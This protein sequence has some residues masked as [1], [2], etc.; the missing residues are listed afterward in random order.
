MRC[1]GLNVLFDSLARSTFTDFEMVLVDGLYQHRADIVRREAWSRFLRVAHVE[2]SPNP[3]PS[4][5]FCQYSNTG[6]IHASG[7]VVLFLVDYTRVPPDLL[8]KHAEF[9]RADTTGRKGMMGPHRYVRLDVHRDWPRY[10]PGD[11]DKYEADVQAGDLDE[12]IFSIGD[13][14]DQPSAP[15]RVDGG[16][17]AQPDADPKLRMNAGPITADFFHAKNESVRLERCLEINGWD[18]ALDGA[19]VHQD[20]DFADRLSLRA[21]VTWTL[22]P[23]AVVDIANPRG[24]FPFARRTRSW[25]SNRER[26]QK[27]KAAGYPTPNSYSLR[28]RRTTPMATALPTVAVSPLR[29][30]MVYGEFSTAIHGPF[31]PPNLHNAALTGSESSFFNLARTMA[32]RGHQVVAFCVCPEPYEHP[33]GLVI[34]PIQALRGLP[35]M[36]LEAVIAWNEPDYLQFAPTDV[37]RVVDQQ[38]NDFGY[39]RHP[40]WRALVDLWVSPSRHHLDHLIATEGVPGEHSFVVPNSVDLDLFCGPEPERHPHRAVWCSSPDRGLHHLLSMWPD[41]RAVVPDAELR[42]FYRLGPWL[43]RVRDMDDEVGRRARYIEYA[44][45]RLRVHG[46][47]VV[48]PVANAQMATE[49]R[50]AKLLAY[51]CDPVRYTEGFGCSVLDAAAAGCVPLISDADALPSVHRSGCIAIQGKPADRREAWIKFIVGILQHDA[52]PPDDQERM[53]RHAL[54]HSREAVAEQWERLIRGRIA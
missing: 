37:L 18:E 49:L 35:Q 34:M 3:F 36:Q 22:D 10:A 31:D 48:G 2:P 9:H 24:V 39:C 6:L 45:P 11:V 13:A 32:E 42:V 25:E 38:L 29:I 8:G 12:F 44:L 15:W 30:A 23:S 52:I 14:T 20:S 50:S 5:A 28:E 17:L 26:W 40:D 27:A 19:H 21:G 4:V 43:E 51:P 46:V 41:V 7:E 47:T 53:R 1:G 54:R 33:S 16:A